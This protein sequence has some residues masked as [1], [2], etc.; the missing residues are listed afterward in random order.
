MTKR[1]LSSNLLLNPSAEFLILCIIFLVLKSPF[2]FF[3]KL[4]S[5]L[6]SSAHFLFLSTLITII[7]SL[8]IK[9]LYQLG[10]LMSSCIVIECW[11]FYMEKCI[12]PEWCYLLPEIIYCSCVL[13]LN[14]GRSS[15]ANQGLRNFNAEFK[16]LW[17]LIYFLFA[18]FPENLEYFPG[19]LF[20]VVP[21]LYFLSL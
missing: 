7:L 8:K 13:Q 18:L 20:W 2:D 4:G 21:H 14:S 6:N 1:S 3:Y 9:Y 12:N 16:S 10:G 17:K 15:W 11:I 5:L 19:P